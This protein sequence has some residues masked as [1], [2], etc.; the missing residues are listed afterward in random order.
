MSIGRQHHAETL[1]KGQ[2]KKPKGQKVKAQEEPWKKGERSTFLRLKGSPE[3]CPGNI[4][5]AC[6]MMAG[7]WLKDRPTKK[8]Q[9]VS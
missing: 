1:A 5:K 8:R 9:I 4:K 2:P 6:S 3:S 7:C